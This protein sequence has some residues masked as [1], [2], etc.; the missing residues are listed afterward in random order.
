MT[1]STNTPSATP[2]NMP[3]TAL[4]PKIDVRSW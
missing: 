2:P 1:M 3:V 4:K